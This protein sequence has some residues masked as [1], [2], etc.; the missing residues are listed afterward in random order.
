MPQCIMDLQVLDDPAGLF[1]R[2]LLVQLCRL[3]GVEVIHYENDLFCVWI[4]YINK[5]LYLLIPINCGT[6]FSYTVM[7]AT[8]QRFYKG[9]NF[10]ALSARSVRRLLRAVF[11]EFEAVA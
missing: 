10:C 8:A 5:I 11:F 7:M 3:V 6:M 2:E 4:H 9:E 1:R